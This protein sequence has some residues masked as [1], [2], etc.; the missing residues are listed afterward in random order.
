LSELALSVQQ[1]RPFAHS[2]Y[3]QVSEI[4]VFL[5][6]P[7]LCLAL[8]Q[9]APAHSEPKTYTAQSGAT[10]TFPMGDASFADE[11]VLFEIGEPAAAAQF[12]NP[13]DAVAVPDYDQPTET[14]SI[15]LGCHGRLTLAFADNAL[16]D[17]PGPDLFVF[18]V[19]PAVEPTALSIS[20]DGQ[21]WTQVGL[22][23]GGT[24]EVDIAGFVP[25]G[26]AF[27]FVRLTDLGTDCGGDFPG[28]DVDAVGAIGSATKLSLDASVLF[29][30][31]KFDLKPAAEPILAAAADQIRLTTDPQITV[32]GH[33]DSVGSDADNMVLSQNRADQVLAYLVGQGFDPASLRASAFGETQ[34]IADNDTDAGRE[35]NRRVE[36]VVQGTVAPG[37]E[38]TPSRVSL[39]IWTTT[40]GL[41]DLVRAEDSVTGNYGSFGRITGS[42]TSPTEFTGFWIEAED[43]SCPDLKLGSAKWGT[44]SVTF[45]SADLDSFQALWG[46]CGGEPGNSGW[47]GD[48]IQF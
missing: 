30:S 35:K 13:Q 2:F 20:A 46:D 45:T 19:G 16:V 32:E 43:G 40:E 8:I 7:L 44:L 24:A 36:I 17:L 33:T 5:R 11:V 6:L 41:M 47:T 1:A 48:R 14:G 37:G 42:F 22:I 28:A 23:S 39:G 26:A 18:E 10:I 12:S 3:F 27:R 15:T 38:A 9:T 25:A 21:A 31:G 4:V 34:P 29:D